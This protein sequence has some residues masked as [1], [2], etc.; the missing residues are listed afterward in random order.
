MIPQPEIEA[1]SNTWFALKEYY[2][3][4]LDMFRKQNDNPKSVEETA[5]LR[6]QIAEIKHLL[7]LE[8]I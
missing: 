4:R 3:E 8:K 2:T 1:N 7:N 5:K 6:G